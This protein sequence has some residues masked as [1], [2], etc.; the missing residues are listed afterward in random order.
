VIDRL[1]GRTEWPSCAV[2]CS[3]AGW[4]RQR[5]LAL[6]LAAGFGLLA[7]WRFGW[8]FTALTTALY[9]WILLAF[10]IIDLE[11]RLV[12]DR[13]LLVALP[14]VLVLNLLVQHP[15]IFSSL[16]GGLVGLAIFSLI[17]TIRPDGMG[18][19]DVKLAGLIG[20]MVGFPDVVFA[21]LLGMIAGG[22]AA[23]ILIYQGQD[24]QQTMAYAPFLAIGAGIVMYWV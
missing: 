13:L 23:L 3:F 20:L 7:G 12:P 1:V 19:G 6:A 11:Q 8:D 9:A 4:S 2:L 16:V 5:L 17:H 21:L 24:R 18:R 10:A 15:A 14:V 22:L